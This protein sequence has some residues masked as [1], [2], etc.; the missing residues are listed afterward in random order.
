[1]AAFFGF[2]AGGPVAR[3]RS[4]PDTAAFAEQ[5]GLDIGVI[6]EMRQRARTL[7]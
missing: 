3:G 5:T 7:A 2:H 6:R 4:Y 1:M